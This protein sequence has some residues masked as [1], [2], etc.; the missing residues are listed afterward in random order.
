LSS[1]I[2]FFSLLFFIYIVFKKGASDLLQNQFL[3]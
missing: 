2:L 3:L 1:E